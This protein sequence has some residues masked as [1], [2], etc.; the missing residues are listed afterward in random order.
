MAVLNR[1]I[2]PEGSV[3]PVLRTWPVEAPR[4]A[5]VVVHGLGEHSG[6]YTR[7][8]EAMGAEGVLTISY[9]QRGHGRSPGRPGDASFAALE[10]DLRTLLLEARRGDATCL[11]VFLLGH[12]MGGLIAL[13]HAL[14]APEGLS[15]L[16]LS[17]PWLATRFPVPP[18]KRR[19]GRLAARVAPWVS[20]STGVLPEHISSDPGEARAYEADPLIHGRITARLHAGAEE[21]QRVTLRGRCALKVPALVLVP[22]DDGLADSRVTLDFMRGLRGGP[23]EVIQLAGCR[24][25]PFSDPAWNG[26]LRQVLDWMEKR[27][28]EA[29]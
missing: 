15:G 25:E 24:H 6:R 22:G 29:P 13:R 1:E 8:A 9:D 12:S 2:H 21:A 5:L 23:V 28:D 3:R 18:W 4:A 7:V 10:G 27:L 17:A 26:T 16:I 19:L 14:A 11:P 20:L